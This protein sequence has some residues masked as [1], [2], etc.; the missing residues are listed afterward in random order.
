MCAPGE[1]ALQRSPSRMEGRRLPV[2][3]ALA[4]HENPTD[5][6]LVGASRGLRVVHRAGRAPSCVALR[7]HLA[8]SR[9]RWPSGR[10]ATSIANRH[11]VSRNAPAARAALGGVGQRDH[12]RFI[13]FP[14]TRL[15]QRLGAAGPRRQGRGLVSLAGRRCTKGVL[16]NRCTGQARAGLTCERLASSIRSLHLLAWKAGA[17]R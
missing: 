2:N 15:R 16:T 7:A 6:N 8:T 10:R 12:D 1:I 11:Q 9:S 17:C 14:A 4:R 3:F 5:G 13:G